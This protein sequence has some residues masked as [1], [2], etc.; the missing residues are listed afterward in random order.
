MGSRGPAL[1][2]KKR[3]LSRVDIVAMQVARSLGAS[4][5]RT[6]RTRKIKRIPDFMRV[7][8]FG[9]DGKVN[10]TLFYF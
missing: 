6:S 1:R 8:L 10:T 2:A 3:L 7:C 5:N 4:L 9:L